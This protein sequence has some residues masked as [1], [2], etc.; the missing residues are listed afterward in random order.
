MSQNFE[1]GPGFDFMLK[2]E[3]DYFS[4]F[5]KIEGRTYIKNLSHSSFHRMF[6]LSM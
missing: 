4:R 3:D 5:H 6:S 1:I 2:N